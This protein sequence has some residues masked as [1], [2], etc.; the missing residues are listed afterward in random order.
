MT[1]DSWKVLGSTKGSRSS[2]RARRFAAAVLVAASVASG[3]LALAADSFRFHGSGYGHGI[4]M[5]Q[6]GA[7]GLARM[8]WSYRKI[9]GHYY[10]G[11]R[12]ESPRL[13]K[14]IRVGLT[15]G[16]SRIHLRPESGPARLWI[17]APGGTAVAR[18]PGGQTWTV[19][20]ARTRHRYVIRDENR[21]VVGG[22]AW[23]GPSAPLFVTYGK[24]GSR[25]TVPEEGITYPYG[26]LEF[27]LV[28][29]GSACSLRLTNQLPLERYLRGLGEMPSSW[30][31]DALRTQAVAAR[32]FAAHR[33][34]RGGLRAS[35][36]CHVSDGV[37]DQ[38]YVGW[39]KEAGPSGDRWVA[40]VGATSG[41]VVTYRGSL[42]QAFYS[43]SNGGHSEDVE[44]VW[45]GGNPAYAIPYLRGVCDPGEHAAGSPWTDWTRTVDAGTVT[46]RLRP[47]TGRIGTVTRFT[48]AVRG[49]SGRIVSVVAR[50]RAGSARVSGS[51]LRSALGLPDTRVWINSDRNVVG[52]IRTLYDR[53]R[54]RPGLP[55]SGVGAVRHGSRQLFEVGGIYR[56]GPSGLTVWVRG[57]VHEEY[58]A[59]GGAGG[60]LGLPTS[61]VRPAGCRSC[62][63]LLL[64]RGRI[65]SK[66]R[67]GAHA[68]WGDVLKAYLARD[69]A[70]GPLGFPTSRVHVRAGVR[71]ATFEHGTISC[72]NG[73]CD[74]RSS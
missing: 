52:P 22:R 39:S 59:V 56:H 50:G 3:P 1:A 2:R 67:I 13:P 33:V 71:R 66:A 43:A 29:C 62:R 55:R 27:D 45:H 30:P 14:R 36:D 7:N 64:E 15:S 23:G 18:I 4:G 19:S 8:G 24:G 9:L 51:E 72:A 41:E 28:S 21:K 5:S 47:Y 12:V 65:Y 70:N 49:R 32:T 34:T 11:T 38:V 20:R 60:R 61:A 48:G 16:R 74:V 44:D 35:C 40:A 26:F 37:S 6:W 42:I 58:L 53:L 57:A 54:C 69:G 10:R 73:A 68:L 31:A 17:G 63:R 46:A 25:V